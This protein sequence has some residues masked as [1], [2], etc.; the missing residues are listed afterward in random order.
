MVDKEKKSQVVGISND[1]TE[2]EF[3]SVTSDAPYPS[4]DTWD[5]AQSARAAMGP[6]SPYTND[7]VG[8]NRHDL[9]DYLTLI[10]ILLFGGTSFVSVAAGWS[11]YISILN[12]GA[13][14]LIAFAAAYRFMR[15]RPDHLRA[16]QSDLILRIA[17]EC[18]SYMRAGLSAETAAKVCAIVL[19]NSPSAVSVAIT[20]CDRVLG[21]QGVGNDHHSVGKPIVTRATHET[22]E[23][24]EPRVINTK[25]EIGCPDPACPLVA[26]IIVPLKAQG[27]AIGTLKFYYDDERHLNETELA[28][29]EGLASLLSTQLE[30][31]EL[32][33]Q[34]AL[35]AEMELK[36]LQAQINPHF[37]FNTLNTISSYIRTD[38][39]EARDLLKKFAR[40]YRHTLEQADT[41]VTL[42]DEVS[43]LEQYF[44]LEQARFG[45]RLELNLSIDET[46]LDEPLPSF[47]LQP[48]VENSIGHGMRATGEPLTIF[49]HA[50][51]DAERNII[52]TVEDDGCGIPADKL[53]TIF[54]QYAGK[55]LGIALRNVRD[56]LNGVFG[57]ESRFK[58]TSVEGTGTRAAFF[59]A[60]TSRALI[61]NR[62]KQEQSAA[63]QSEEPAPSAQDLGF[64]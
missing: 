33:E 19:R 37:L 35:V 28:M 17:R 3:A 44:A 13:L 64:D 31:H 38:P 12:V 15:V 23:Q 24:N 54:D 56:R 1:P 32:E 7:L 14:V 50:Y 55:G 45:D 40:F 26:A 30:I 46:L 58:I 39:N 5:A 22:I 36:A 34:T 27:S 60:A 47:M 25:R 59:I 49:V 57:A 53:S 51:R 41:E 52:M 4:A 11:R 29:A 43:F 62:P 21:F 8:V 2:E 20:D 48:L 6:T 61:E 63:A 9:V 18:L 42:G 16:Q 10:L